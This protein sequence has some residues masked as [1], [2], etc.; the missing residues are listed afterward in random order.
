MGAA[1]PEVPVLRD[2]RD[3]G[4]AIRRAR[5]VG[6]VRPGA[7]CRCGR[8]D[9]LRGDCLG[10]AKA[11]GFSE[12]SGPLQSA[13]ANRAAERAAH[14]VDMLLGVPRSAG[15]VD[16]AGARLSRQQEQAGFD[17]ALA[18]E[19]VLVADEV[20]VNVLARAPSRS[21][22]T[23]KENPQDG[24]KAAS[25][26]PHVLVVRTPDER[27]T[28][29]QALGSRRKEDVTAGGPALFTGFPDHRRVQGLPAA[30]FRLAGV[31]QCCQH[32]I[33]RCRAV[34]KLGLGSL[35]SW[36]AD[37]I[38][39]VREAHQA[40]QEARARGTRPGPSDSWRSSPALR[41]GRRLRDHP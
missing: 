1:G 11:T 3:R 15:W 27:L 17:A 36:A 32:V 41:R 37:V 29:L 2:R 4:P 28:W 10:Y 22:R 26:A 21:R 5:R 14:V 39:I 25:S 9:L 33:R 24:G 7:E 23:R 30:P 34:T 13:T 20:P 19:P 16:K 35:P 38:S 8:A 40:V 18:A 12:E 6:A 31:W